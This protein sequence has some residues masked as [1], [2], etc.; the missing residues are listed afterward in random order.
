MVTALTLA[1]NMQHHGGGWG[2]GALWFVFPLL[3]FLLFATLIFLVA[4]RA[5]RGPGWGPNGPWAYQAPS[6]TP[7]GGDPVTILAQRFARGEI[8]EAEFRAR[9]AVLRTGGPVSD[10]GSTPG[11]TP[12]A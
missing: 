1:S 5:R 4:R 10:A 11:E 12:K 2:P 9:L 3:W 8:D 7:S 6:G